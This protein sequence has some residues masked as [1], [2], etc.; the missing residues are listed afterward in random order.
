VRGRLTGGQELLEPAP[1]PAVGDGGWHTAAASA[2]LALLVTL[3]AGDLLILAFGQAPG[4]VWRMLLTGTWGN[5]YGAGQVLYKATT[6][7]FTGLAVSLGL[8]AGLF[9][10]GAEG[11]LAAGGFAAAVV[12]LLLPPG[13]PAVLAVP[14]CLL[15]AAAGAARWGRCRA[16]SRPASARTR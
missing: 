16:C 13:L 9:N 3:V 11:Q 10:I 2:A 6:L 8:R 12:G 15:A 5:F 4:E 14:L 1:P 7:V